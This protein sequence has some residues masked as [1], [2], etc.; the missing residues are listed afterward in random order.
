VLK[1]TRLRG[2][3][4]S[5]ILS[6]LRIFFAKKKKMT[7]VSMSHCLLIKYKF[8]KMSRDKKRPDIILKDSKKRWKVSSRA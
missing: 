4:G 2:E 7:V 5:M 8:Q 6:K 1:I 3:T